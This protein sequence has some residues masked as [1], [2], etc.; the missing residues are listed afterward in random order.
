MNCQTYEEVIQNICDRVEKY[1]GIKIECLGHSCQCEGKSEVLHQIDILIS[2]SPDRDRIYKIAIE[3]QHWHKK[4]SKDVVMKLHCIC[5]DCKMSKGIIIS[6]IGFT[7][8]AIKYAQYAN[9]SLVKL[10]EIESEDLQEIIV[11][12]AATITH[13]H[14]LQKMSDREFMKSVIINPSLDFLNDPEEDIYTL[15]DGQPFHV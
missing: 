5:E 2:Y 7:T 1:D 11:N 13:F 8:D 9:I 12:L 3:C 6:N 4:I 10:Q 14:N 15:E